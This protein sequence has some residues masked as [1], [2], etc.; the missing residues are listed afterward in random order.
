MLSTE[1]Q[2]GEAYTLKIDQ[3]AS[4]GRYYSV[5]LDDTTLSVKKFRSQLS[6]PVPDTLDVYV[7]DMHD[8]VP[9][10]SQDIRVIIGQRYKEGEQYRFKIR[11][12]QP[13]SPRSYNLAD[14][15]GLLFV[16]NNA[17]ANLRPGTHVWCTVRRVN[18]LTVRLRYCGELS[19]PMNISFKTA[20]EWMEIG[21]FEDKEDYM[22]LMHD[23]A[24]FSEAID[25]YYSENSN[26][27]FTAIKTF[28]ENIPIWLEKE[29]SR[30]EGHAD[31]AVNSE[32]MRRN[33]RL[34]LGVNNICRYIIENSGYLRGC[35]QAQRTEYR[36]VI[37][38]HMEK[39]Q[40]Y[41]ESVTSIAD[42]S[43]I[44]FIDTILR[45]LREAGYM[46]HHYEQFRKMVII[47]RL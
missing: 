19:A 21:G 40:Q 16:L 43:H 30:W 20:D 27:I 37:E 10:I 24:A 8:G 9:L 6:E 18:K 31:D 46:Y 13:G 45:N 14:D 5:I 4:M 33:A 38:A 7:K 12:T 36:N 41:A 32:L 35:N 25:Q 11:S 29:G 42:G 15:N 22:S 26:W 28:V 3:E 39:L 2:K 17:P 47:L 23:R 34:I 44:E 1:L